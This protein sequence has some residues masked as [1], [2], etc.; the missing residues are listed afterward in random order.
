MGA[1]FGAL[2]FPAS[3]FA[4]APQPTIGEVRNWV[5]LDDA[6][7]GI[8]SKPFVLRGLGPHTEVWVAT[9]FSNPGGLGGAY[10]LE[11]PANYRTRGRDQDCRNAYTNVTDAQIQYLIDQYENVIRPKEFSTYEPLPARNGTHAA[12]S[13]A[14]SSR[15]NPLGPGDDLIILID[16]VRDTEFYS[17]QNAKGL[18]R[19]GGFF[20]PTLNELFDRNFMTIDPEYLTARMGPNPQGSNWTGP[21][22]PLGTLTREC[23]NRV[24]PTPFGTEG[25]FAHEFQHELEYYADPNEILWVNEGLSDF[26]EALTGYSNPALA[27]PAPGFDSHIWSFL[28]WWNLA[29]PDDPLSSGGPENSLTIWG[30]QTDQPNEIL[31]DYGAAYTFMLYLNDRFGTSFM[32]ALHQ[33]PGVGLQGL[34]NVLEKFNVSESPTDVIHDWAAMVALDQPLD[35]GRTLTGGTP[36]TY[37]SKSL[38]ATIN[39]DNSEA[40]SH[41]GVP[42]NGSD[43]VRL[44]DASGKY[45]S[46]SQINSVSFKGDTTYPTK[47]NSVTN[48]PGREGNAVLYSGQGD[49][50][51]VAVSRQIA[52]PAGSNATLTF[53]TRWNIEQGW[54][55]GFVQVVG[56]TD[57]TPK[58][59]ACTDTTSTQDPEAADLASQGEEPWATIKANLPGFTGDS[60]GWKTETCSLAAYAGQTVTVRFRYITDEATNGTN[61]DVAPGWWI[62]DVAVNGAVVSNGT[63]TGWDFAPLK[64][65]N[66]LVRLVGW[67]TT[68]K[69]AP[70]FIATIK[71]DSNFSGTL[72]GA[73]LRAAIGDKADIVA[74]I[75]TLDDPTEGA[76]DPAN[77]T[78]VVNGVEQPGGGG[79]AT[80]AAT[81]S[82]AAAEQS[83]APRQHAL[84]RASHH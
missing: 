3:S 25:V 59:L 83:A 22:P 12:K 5:A 26:T 36:A 29:V 66:W 74:A 55:F 4:D 67:S 39:W 35:Q 51:D 8:Y 13:I 1:V 81:A 77:Y 17:F 60:G 57:T 28:G 69:S 15:F 41:P 16:N 42:P 50:L 27:P 6:T 62:D 72:S 34:A 46:A 48:A 68:D 53:Q 70:A 61:P 65:A 14:S 43:Y 80:A 33:D 79:A 38:N 82:T 24:I 18:S 45:V 30:D 11:F 32:T 31:S 58:S 76:V 73:D 56:T 63:A 40:Y 21:L 52:V 49:G 19:I 20:S 64:V 71:L 54:D 2:T 78:L 9:G 75:V 10:G 47:W 44:R 37:Q 7:N 84:Q 23:I